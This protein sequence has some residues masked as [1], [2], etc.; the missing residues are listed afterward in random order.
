[1]PI[2]ECVR[3][4]PG[5][6]VVKSLELIGSGPVALLHTQKFGIQYKKPTKTPAERHRCIL[7]H[8]RFWEQSRTC[9][10]VL[11]MPAFD[12][13]CVK[14]RSSQGCAE[15]FS[16]LPSFDRSCQCNW[17]SRR[18]NRDGNSTRKLNVRVFTQGTWGRQGHE[19]GHPKSAT[20]CLGQASH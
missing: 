13:G 9:R 6:V 3:S 2:S 11:A 14:T 17:F 12:P 15:L 1:M 10:E 8:V 5:W 18:R 7:P 16:Q 4:S 20:C 19:T